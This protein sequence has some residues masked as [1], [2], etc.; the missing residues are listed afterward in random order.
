MYLKCK[1]EGC[2]NMWVKN[3][4]CTGAVPVWK[5]KKNTA[6]N[7]QQLVK[8]NPKTGVSEMDFFKNTATE[9]KEEF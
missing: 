7:Q 4:D 1:S 8:K 9:K 5:T 3:Q 6:I 2:L